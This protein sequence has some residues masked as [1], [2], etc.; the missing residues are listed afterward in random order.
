MIQRQHRC[1]LF[2]LTSFTKKT[3][4][5]IRASRTRINGS[6]QRL[7]TLIWLGG[8]LPS[9]PHAHRS[10][11]SK[12][13]VTTLLFH[14]LPLLLRRLRVTLRLSIHHLYL[15][16]CA[17]RTLPRGQLLW[18]TPTTSCALVCEE[19]GSCRDCRDLSCALLPT[20]NLFALFT[21][22]FSFY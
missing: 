22:V 21:L 12:V 1:I 13:L 5:V 18:T 17:V 19:Q 10:N 6:R 8:P 15:Y 3:S 7:S 11:S 16:R 2:L 4:T 9:Q 20:N 14:L